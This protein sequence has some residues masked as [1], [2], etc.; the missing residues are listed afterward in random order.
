MHYIE[1]INTNVCRDFQAALFDFDGT[2]SLIRE[3]W[4]PIM[5]SYFTQVLAESSPK[6][7]LER[8]EAQVK[9]YVDQSTGIQAIYQCFWLA[10]EVERRGGK[11]KDPLFYKEEYNRRLLRRISHRTQA[12]RSGEARP[13]DYLVPGS[14]ELLEEL[15]R[16]GLTLYLASGTDHKYVVEEA[17][18]LGVSSFF[19]GGIYGAVEDYKNFSKEQVIR[20]LIL[21]K[22]PSGESLLGFGDG[23]VEIENVKSVGGIAVGVASNEKARQGIDAWKRERLIKAGADVI[24]GDYRARKEL[25]E[26]LFG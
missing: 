4:Q 25:L 9:E 16:R 21:P 13:E 14:V 24:V 20:K 22:I 26:G 2:I 15:R 12:L 11:P 10:E 17:E 5:Y 7:P 6:E 23:F 8:L 19:S 1:W 18:A 3:D